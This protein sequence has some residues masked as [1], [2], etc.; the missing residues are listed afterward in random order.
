MKILTEQVFETIQKPDVESAEFQKMSRGEQLKL[1]N[2]YKEYRLE[3]KVYDK[4]METGKTVNEVFY[5]DS[6]IDMWK[7][8]VALTRYAML[9]ETHNTDADY[10]SSFRRHSYS[11]ECAKTKDVETRFEILGC[12]KTF[13][14]RPYLAPA[15]QTAYGFF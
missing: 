8:D 2:A 1:I 12:V 15:L 11:F 14:A 13:S 10:T 4:V 7:K 9:K 3:M 6:E 5:N